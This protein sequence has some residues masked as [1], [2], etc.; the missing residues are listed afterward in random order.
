MLAQRDAE[1][2]QLKYDHQIRERR[3]LAQ[4]ATVRKANSNE[5]LK[6]PGTQAETLQRICNPPTLV[7]QLK[8]LTQQA[9]E[10]RILTQREF[11]E[12]Y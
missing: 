10:L 1:I 9:A 6:S 2:T 7:D 11:V 8:E 4:L 12:E 5:Q 3:L